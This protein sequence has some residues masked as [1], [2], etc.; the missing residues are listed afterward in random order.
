VRSSWSNWKSSEN[1]IKTTVGQVRSGSA[2]LNGYWEQYRIGRRQ[3]LDLLNAQSDLYN[4]QVNQVAAKYD[5]LNFRATIL[6]N[7]GRLA[8]SYQSY[9]P[10]P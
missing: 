2:V 5:T 8:N 3:V 7:I 1:R 6:A 9:S 10:R 4:Y